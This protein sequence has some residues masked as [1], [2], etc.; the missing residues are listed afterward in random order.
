MAM[1][2]KCVILTRLAGATTRFDRTKLLKRQ[3][4]EVPNLT[5]DAREGRL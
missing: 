1:P 2:K 3:L 5:S 4:R